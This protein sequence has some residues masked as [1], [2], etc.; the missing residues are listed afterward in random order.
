MA[1]SKYSV[2]VMSGLWRRNWDGVGTKL[3]DLSRLDQAGIPFYPVEQTGVVGL[4]WDGV[5]L[6]TFPLFATV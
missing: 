6:S 5:V 3:P 4:S 1:A 2:L